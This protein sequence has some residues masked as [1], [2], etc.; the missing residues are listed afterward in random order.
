[1]ALY[2]T[3]RFA[4]LTLQNSA[5]ALAKSL[6]CTR[7]ITVKVR[8][9]SE[10][11]LFPIHGGNVKFVNTDNHVR[12]RGRADKYAYLE[13][14]FFGSTTTSF[15]YDCHQDSCKFISVESADICICATIDMT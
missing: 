9:V 4:I 7:V 8:K 13:I 6:F 12:R 11:A 15:W 14:F 3:T 5:Q 10:T 2:F 1:M